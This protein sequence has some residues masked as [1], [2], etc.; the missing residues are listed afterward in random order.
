MLGNAASALPRD[1]AKLLASMGHQ[2]V[3][4]I[5]F[6]GQYSQLIVRRVRE[7]GCYSEMVPWMKAAEKIAERRPDAVILSGGPRSVLE[8]GAPDLDMF[9]RP[10]AHEE[11]PAQSVGAP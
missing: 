6:G 8:A 5:D 3:L 2:F 7:L 1:C 4:V 9:S 11:V 10:A